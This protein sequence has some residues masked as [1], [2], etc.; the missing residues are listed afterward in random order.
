MIDYILQNAV[1]ELLGE[2]HVRDGGVDFCESDF[3]RGLE[4]SMTV[5]RVGM[6]AWMRGK[7]H[8]VNPRKVSYVLIMTH[9]YTNTLT[10]VV[11]IVATT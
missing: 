1:E 11:N 3:L 5:V 8:P 7:G 9:N 4:P 2:S 6:N 10:S